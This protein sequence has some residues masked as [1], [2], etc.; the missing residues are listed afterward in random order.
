LRSASREVGASQAV[1]FPGADCGASAPKSARSSRAGVLAARTTRSTR[2]VRALLDLAVEARVLETARRW[3]ATLAADSETPDLTLEPWR[4][5]P[6][7]TVHG[8]EQVTRSPIF[9]TPPQVRHE[10]ECHRVHQTSRRRR[11]AA[12]SATSAADRSV[13]APSDRQPQPPGSTWPGSP[14]LASPV[15]GSGLDAGPPVG[16][17]DVVR[18]SDVDPAPVEVPGVGGPDVVVVSD[19]VASDVVAA[20]VVAVSPPVEDEASPPVP[21]RPEVEVSVASEVVRSGSGPHAPARQMPSMQG[22]P[23]TTGPSAGQSNAAPSQNSAP[24]HGPAAGRQ[25]RP[26]A[27]GPHAPSTAAPAATLHAAQS[28]GSE[29]PQAASQHTPSMH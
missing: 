2:V 18:A 14:E 28:S 17:S 20:D 29:L 16:V 23:S 9:P 6:S 11:L 5:P 26:V 21:S 27:R 10:G 15:G 24:S 19:V 25:V 13:G 7:A 3:L 4:D 22:V 12:E 1:A 8:L